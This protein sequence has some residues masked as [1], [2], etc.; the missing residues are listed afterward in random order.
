MHQRINLK[1]P[2]GYGIQEDWLDLLPKSDC[3]KDLI[4]DPVQKCSFKPKPPIINDLRALHFLIRARK[5][6]NVLEFGPGYSSWII[7]DALNKNQKE[8]GIPFAKSF[9][10][11]NPFVCF[12]V[13]DSKY[14]IKKTRCKIPDKLQQHIKFSFSPVR[15]KSFNGRPCTFHDKLPNC[16]PELIYLD[17]PDQWTCQGAF[18]G[19]HTR[20]KER[21]PVAGDVL[22][23]EP[24]LIPGCLIVAD[25]RTNN[26]RFLINNLQRKWTHSTKNDMHFLELQEKPLGKINERYLKFAK[27]KY[28]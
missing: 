4:W 8:I 28:K 7:A 15:M 10:K 20:H 23:Y 17:G 26:I 19:L 9:R 16:N 1:L 21:T 22:L 2:R 12:S 11:E 13:G 3:I 6:F 27:S 14:W 25:G 5:V 18:H 24:Y